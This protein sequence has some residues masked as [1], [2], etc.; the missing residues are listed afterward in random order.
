PQE[1]QIIVYSQKKY[2]TKLRYANEPVRHKI[3]D[4]L[5]DMALLGHQL[6]G[7]IIIYRPGH[8]FTHQIIKQIIKLVN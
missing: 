3:L 6:Q 2:I 7:K 8:D 4:F 1:S 5:G